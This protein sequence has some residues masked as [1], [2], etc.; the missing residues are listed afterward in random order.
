MRRN[1][2]AVLNAWR[3]GKARK[4]QSCSTDGTRIYSYA[5]CLVEREA[6]GR[7]LLNRT[8][9]SR[10]TTAQQRSLLVALTYAL[11]VDGV[12]IGCRGDL[13]RYAS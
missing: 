7:V 8:T 5:T 3:L 1:L 4:G 6:D 13:G 11:E 10:T 9:Y 2:S 12:P